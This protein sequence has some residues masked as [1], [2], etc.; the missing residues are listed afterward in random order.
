MFRNNEKPFRAA[1]AASGAAVLLMSFT[2][3]AAAFAVVWLSY[4]LLTQS[5]RLEFFMRAAQAN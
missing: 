3:S 4:L 2:V 1:E 5:M